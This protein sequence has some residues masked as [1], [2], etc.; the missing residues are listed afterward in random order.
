MS[1]LL[2]NTT[3]KV[4]SDKSK[5]QSVPKYKPRYIRF[6]VDA[7]IDQLFSQLKSENPFFSEL[8]IVRFILGKFARQNGYQLDVSTPAILKTAESYEQTFTKSTL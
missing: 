4:T 2:K 6:P 3:K 1:I 7:T 8:D 5:N